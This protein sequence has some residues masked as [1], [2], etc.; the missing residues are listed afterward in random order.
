[1]DEPMI[2]AWVLDAAA[3]SP[4]YDQA[5]GR[6]VGLDG[7][8]QAGAP[9]LSLALSPGTL[10]PHAGPGPAP[11]TVASPQ[12]TGWTAQTWVAY[13]VNADG[14]LDQAGEAGL[15]T[16]HDSAPLEAPLDI[17]G[18]PELT[19][20]V[21]SD[22]AQANLAA[23][24]SMVAPDGKATFISHGVLNLTHRDSHADPAPM[25]P[26]TPVPVRL[27]LNVIGQHVP[28]GYRLRLALSSAYWPLIWP[29]AEAAELTLTDATLRLPLLPADAQTALPDLPAAEGAQPADLA[30]VDPPR[31]TRTRSIDCIT[32]VETTTRHDH[33]GAYRHAHTGLTVAVDCHEV[34]RIHPDDPNSAKGTCTWHWRAERDDWFADLQTQVSVTAERT[35]WRIE[36]TLTATD[37]DG[38]VDRRT[39]SE[40][41]ARDMV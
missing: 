34:Y 33:R 36:A 10:T 24:L 41:I 11:I 14:P 29:S 16:L 39:W 22:V 21:A 38:I 26:D 27:Q 9:Q 19:L 30:E 1:M 23:V 31:Y 25:P 35:N 2:R 12:T 15:A 17:L 4:V 13:G 32:G 28:A 7:W 8:P 3:P 37:A 18:F 6:W 20:T 40:R 5:P